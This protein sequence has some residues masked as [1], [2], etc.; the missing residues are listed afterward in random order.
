M[1]APGSTGSFAE[2]RFIHSRSPRPPRRQLGAPPSS[3][4][5]KPAPQRAPSRYCLPHHA[6]GARSHQPDLPGDPT[7]IPRPA[8]PI[9]R[10]DPSACPAPPAH[11]TVEWDRF[12]RRQAAWTQP[13]LPRPLT[14]LSLRPPARAPCSPT[15]QL[16]DPGRPPTWRQSASGAAWLRSVTGWRWIGRP[17]SLEPANLPQPPW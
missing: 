4:C 8:P 6:S 5:P 11:A 16:A 12:R 17:G 1:A 14:G 2:P 9:D 7:K 15:R 10:R 13:P 3:G